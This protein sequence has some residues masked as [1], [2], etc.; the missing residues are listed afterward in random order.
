M[1]VINANKHFS[2]QNIFTSHSA[3]ISS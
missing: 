2:Q 3:L 1:A